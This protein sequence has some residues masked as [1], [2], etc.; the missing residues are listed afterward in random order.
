MKKVLFV[1]FYFPP[2]GGGGVQRSS[3]FVKYLREFGWE[4][5]VLTI[6]E[7]AARRLHS[8]SDDDL[9]AEIPSGTEVIRTPF[10]RQLQLLE[11]LRRL[12]MMGPAEFFLYP[13]FWEFYALWYGVAL[14]AARTRLEKGDIDAIYTTSGP[15]S[16][17]RVGASLQDEFGL[18][19][20]ADVRDPY[21]LSHWG[22]PSRLHYRLCRMMERRLL[23][24]AELLVFATEG[25]RA[26]HLAAYPELKPVRTSCIHN[27]YDEEDFASPPPPRDGRYFRIVYAGTVYSGRTRGRPSSLL[28]RINPFRILH[29]PGPLEL[30]R[31]TLAPDAFLKGVRRA[32]DRQPEL[33]STV[34]VEFC[35]TETDT[36]GMEDLIGKLDLQEIVHRRGR[37]S[38][39]SALASIRS[40][41]VLLLTMERRLDGQPSPVTCG[42]LFEYL[43]TQRPILAVG[44][45]GEGVSI[46]QRAGVGRFVPS[47]TVEHIA[48]TIL[49]LHSE[50]RDGK[51][52]CRADTAYIEG[53]ARRR[54]TGRLAD[55]LSGMRM[56]SSPV[57]A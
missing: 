32:I 17:L 34:R 54:L 22:W 35:G 24:Q 43:A 19:W 44:G 28:S 37:V 23:R 53:F 16:A 41:D 49:E 8:G 3:K 15:F 9:L 31:T 51:V 11:R 1:A 45:E 57:P 47:D 33:A 39:A 14:Q 13:W 27:G 36:A 52:D 29:Y 30:D 55:L 20:L 7:D 10:L 38:H 48:A 4:P 26:M 5:V 25:L 18:P 21:T 12:H 6:D 50:W 42:K 40:A 56:R 46:A 2:A